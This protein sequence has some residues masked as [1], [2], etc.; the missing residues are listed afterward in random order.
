MLSNGT[1]LLQVA[2]DLMVFALN[3]SPLMPLRTKNG[4]RP[5]P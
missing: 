3:L 5:K 4:L 1:I 2:K